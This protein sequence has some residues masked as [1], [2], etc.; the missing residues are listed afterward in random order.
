MILGKVVAI[1][2]RDEFVLDA[3]R[4]YIDTPKLDL[5]GRMHGREGHTLERESTSGIEQG[6]RLGAANAIG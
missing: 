3:E 4:C 5:I 1:H 2:V 6:V